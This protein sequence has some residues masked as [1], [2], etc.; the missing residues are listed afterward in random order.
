ADTHK[1]STPS[2]IF[3]PNNSYIQDSSTNTEG[4]VQTEVAE[5]TDVPIPNNT[6]LVPQKME[7]KVAAEE[8]DKPT[9]TTSEMEILMDSKE[10]SSTYTAGNTI[11]S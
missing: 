9:L 1:T 2:P 8:S 6:G 5:T 11:Y 10:P 3:S 7:I 4:E